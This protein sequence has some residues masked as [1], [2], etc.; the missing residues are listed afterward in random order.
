MGLLSNR[1]VTGV[2]AF[3]AFV[4][5]G[6]MSQDLVA[7]TFF[8]TVLFFAGVEWGGLSGLQSIYGKIFYSL[9]VCVLSVVV[10]DLIAVAEENR[11]LAADFILVLWL[12]AFFWLAWYQKTGKGITT[13]KIMLATVGALILVSLSVSVMTIKSSNLY[14]LLS[15]VLVVSCADI[16]AFLGGKFFGRHKL[17][18]NVSPG[19]T[20]EGLIVGI[21]GAMLIGNVLYFVN[22]VLNLYI[23]NAVVAITTLAA[24]VGDLFE[25]MMKRFR[26]VK[27]SGTILPGHGGVLD[28]LDSLCAAAPVYLCALLHAGYII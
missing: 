17:M 4:V 16:F 19:K 7:W 13:N 18:P 6:L 22:P 11:Q 12:A 27:N 1:L 23:W 14:F 25:S 15:L 21:F 9:A 10:L 5:F 2:C 8:L 24:V 20:W 3:A 26:K 28:R